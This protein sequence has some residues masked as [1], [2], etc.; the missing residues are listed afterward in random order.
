MNEADRIL[1]DGLYPDEDV[2][3]DEAKTRFREVFVYGG[4]NGR[5]VFASLMNMLCFWDTVGTE[6]ELYR[7]NAA[8]EILQTMGIGDLEDREKL[9]GLLLDYPISTKFKRTE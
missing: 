9:L 6:E 7:H 5:Y 1:D 3:A 4:E 2:M 8:M